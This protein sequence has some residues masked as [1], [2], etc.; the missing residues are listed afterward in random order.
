MLRR[1]LER[2]W[3]V[4]ACASRLFRCSPMG[5]LGESRMDS[6]W[7]WAPT[8]VASSAILSAA[9][10]MPVSMR[11]SSF[12]SARLYWSSIVSRQ[13]LSTLSR[14]SRPSSATWARLWLFSASSIAGRV[15]PRCG[16]VVYMCRN[17]GSLGEMAGCANDM[18]TENDEL[19]NVRAP[20]TLSWHPPH[21]SWRRP[22]TAARQSK[23]RMHGYIR[24]RLRT[25]QARKTK[26]SR[27]GRAE[28]AEILV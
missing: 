18:E 26:R 23:G 28:V 6:C 15:G 12:S 1:Y 19:V 16:R 3:A 24:R 14:S 21:I 7:P 4:A 27:V 5:T 13:N 11:A 8:R 25:E 22:A 20:S 17:V 9:L 10:S 2:R